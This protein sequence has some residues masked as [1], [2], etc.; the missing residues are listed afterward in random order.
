MASAQINVDIDPACTSSIGEYFAM[1]ARP[2]LDAAMFQ[3][4]QEDWSLQFQKWNVAY[5]FATLIVSVLFLGLRVL[6]ELVHFKLATMIVDIYTTAIY[7]LLGILFAHMGWF[8]VVRKNG[9]CG[10]IGYLI[11]AA[12][13][14][15]LNAA[16]MVNSV[17]S[18]PGV[19]CGLVYAM[20]LVPVGYMVLALF[21]LAVSDSARSPNLV[22][23]TS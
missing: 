18:D 22:G 3:C 20:M 23:A 9:C 4:Q 1:L 17:T 8:C 19:P 5:C 21:K 15:L 16:P 11:W 13:Y 2:R 10:R 14:L 7:L 12:V 6:Q